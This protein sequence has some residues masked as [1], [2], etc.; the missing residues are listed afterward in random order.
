MSAAEFDALGDTDIQHCKAFLC[1]TVE[2]DWA[3]KTEDH[4][5]DPVKVNNMLADATTEHCAYVRD[6]VHKTH[7]Y[8]WQ[9]FARELNL[10]I[11]KLLATYPMFNVYFNSGEHIGSGQWLLAYVWPRIKNHV[12]N[13]VSNLL[14]SID[15]EY[16]IAIIDDCMY[17][18]SATFGLLYRALWPYCQWDNRVITVIPF[19]SAYARDNLEALLPKVDMIFTVNIVAY[20]HDIIPDGMVGRIYPVYF[21]HKIAGELSSIPLVYNNILVTAPDRTMI[22]RIAVLMHAWEKMEQACIET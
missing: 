14:L 3:L 17:S 6:V 11:D 1:S 21:D 8:T 9:A 5:V 22:A 7:H 10:C 18:G 4:S 12:A 13:V 16:P 19:T 2:H 15:N 20:N